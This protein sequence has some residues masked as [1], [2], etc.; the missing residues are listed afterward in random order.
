M[1]CL[2]T[3]FIIDLLKGKKEGRALLDDLEQNEKRI[4]VSAPSVMELWVGAMLC[5]NNDRA[6]S[7]INEFL[8][9]VEILPFD[10]RGAKQAAEIEY[11]LLKRGTPIETEDVMTA[12]IALTQGEKVVT[13]DEHFAR[14]PGLRVVKY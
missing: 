14:I 10:E 3:S 2:D 1:A 7:K 9:S 6:K 12:A 8:S 5:S 13:H 11:T 4:T